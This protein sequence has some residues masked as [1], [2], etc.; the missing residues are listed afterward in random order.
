LLGFGLPTPGRGIA[1]EAISA[2]LLLE[3]TRPLYASVAKHNAA[4]IRVLQKCGF[5]HFED[6]SATH[7]LLKLDAKP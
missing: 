3:Q 1:T 4:S 5:M 7:I 6:D 2:F